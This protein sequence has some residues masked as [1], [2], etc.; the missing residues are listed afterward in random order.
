MGILT[1]LQEELLQVF[2][3]TEE[4]NLFYLTGGT[5][6][7]AHYLKHRYSRDLGLFTKEEEAIGYMGDRIQNNLKAKSIETKTI[8]KLRSFYEI[9][10]I[11]GN[12][13]CPIHLAL[14]SPFR[15]EKPKENLWGVRIDALVDIATNKL[16]TLFGRVEPR[17]F[18]DVFF[19]A[20]EAFS[21]NELI[22]KS[23]QKDPGLDEYY[24][25]I[26]FHQAKEL[27]DDISKL[28]VQM[29]K[30]LDVKEMKEYFIKQAVA[31]IDKAKKLQQFEK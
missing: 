22:E 19:L 5:A 30:P 29:V 17:D 1:A 7:A 28:P 16:L 23:K 4:S 9:L 21:L 18:V 6:L 27:P 31:L 25:A 12:Q 2:A 26:A 3:K 24:L 14:D 11:K 10:A 15:F 8:R 13:E 20:K